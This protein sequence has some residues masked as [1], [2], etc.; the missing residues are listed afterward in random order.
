MTTRDPIMSL[1]RGHERYAC[2]V[3]GCPFDTLDRGRFADHMASVHPLPPP[4]EAPI[5]PPPPSPLAILNATT[6][7][8]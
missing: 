7:R 2:P 1:W 5:I 4:P 6:R 8:R 3:A